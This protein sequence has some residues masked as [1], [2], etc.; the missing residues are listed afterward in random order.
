MEK[1][2]SRFHVG[3]E[4]KEELKVISKNRGFF[5]SNESESS[6]AK[7]SSVFKLSSGKLAGPSFSSFKMRLAG[8]YFLVC[9]TRKATG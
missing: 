4:Q 1:G 9:K 2:K 7:R 8:S 6:P 5:L 3:S